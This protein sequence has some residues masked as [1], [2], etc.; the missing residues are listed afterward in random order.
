M[1]EILLSES[2]RQVPDET[3]LVRDVSLVEAWRTRQGR[4]LEPIRVARGGDRRLVGSPGPHVQEERLGIGR[5]PPDKTR[6]LVGEQVGVVTLDLEHLAI[7][8]DLLVVVLAQPAEPLVPARRDVHLVVAVE[9]LADELG[10]VACA[11]KPGRHRGLVL[12]ACYG[13]CRVPPRAARCS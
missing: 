10:L 9:V 13:T 5:C 8:V 4:T 6:R 2:R 3:G 12:A 1:L 11:V 7:V